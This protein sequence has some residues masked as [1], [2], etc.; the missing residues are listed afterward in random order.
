MNEIINHGVL[1]KHLEQRPTDYKA[2]AFTFVSYEVRNPSGDWRPYLVKKEY[3]KAREDSMSCVSFSA[4]SSIEIQE[5]FITGKEPNYSDRWI[6]KM[7]DTQPDGNWLYKVADVVRNYGMVDEADYPAPPNYTFKQYHAPIPE[8]LK[9]QLIAKGKKWL[10][11]WDVKTEFLA[12]NKPEMMKHIKHAPL[13]IVIP[14]HAIVNFLCEQDIVNYF[15]TYSPFEKKTPY[16][17]IQSAYKYVLTPKN[18]EEPKK[19][20][21]DDHGKIYVVVLQGFAVGG[22]AAK[23]E[24][25][26]AQLKEAFEVPADAPTFNMP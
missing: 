11:K 8:H 14:G 13:Q 1:P 4:C 23:S 16:S 22:G 18:M 17:N 5:K 12:A 19:V 26:L 21:I 2:G 15:D 20:I 9:S 10:E 25:A 6:A 7:S 24:A 3:Q